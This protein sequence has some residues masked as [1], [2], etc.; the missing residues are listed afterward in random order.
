ML[1]KL[2]YGSGIKHLVHD[3]NER[4][5]EATKKE[6]TLNQEDQTAVREHVPADLFG[7]TKSLEAYSKEVLPSVRSS[8]HRS[9]K[10]VA[11]PASKSSFKQ[12]PPTERRAKGSHSQTTS[13]RTRRSRNS[14]TKSSHATSSSVSA[15]TLS[16]SLSQNST[17]TSNSI[18]KLPSVATPI[19]EPKPSKYNTRSLKSNASVIVEHGDLK[20]REYTNDSNGD[21]QS[22]PSTKPHAESD[23]IPK[24]QQVGPHTITIGATHLRIDHCELTFKRY[25]IGYAFFKA[26]LQHKDKL[27]GLIEALGAQD[28]EEIWNGISGW[29]VGSSGAMRLNAR[30][31]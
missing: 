18:S 13:H 25:A 20:A 2:I 3:T 24:T 6:V 21:I 8:R 1:H 29:L 4:E 14:R 31:D 19:V 16:G 17:T 5:L 26:I 28:E 12:A 15:S 22:R 27:D 30:E 23:P 11:N 9:A 10:H 7:F